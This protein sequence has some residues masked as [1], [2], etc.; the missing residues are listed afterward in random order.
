MA[1]P[2]YTALGVA[3]EP[4]FYGFEAAKRWARLCNTA[5][6]IPIQLRYN[7]TNEIVFVIEANGEERSYPR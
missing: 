6:D 2:T 3:S 4:E 1:E 7:P 5:L